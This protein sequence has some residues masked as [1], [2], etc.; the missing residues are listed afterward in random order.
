[1]QAFRQVTVLEPDV[2]NGFENAGSV[3]VQEGKYGEAIPYLQKALQIEADYASYS[4]LGVAYT[5]TKQ[6][7]EAS[8]VLEKAL[9]LNQNDTLTAVNLAD[10]YRGSGQTEKAKAEYQQ[11]ISLGFRELQTNPKDA[12]VMALIA[13]SYAKTG[14]AQQAETFIQRA[15]AEHKDD[16]D[17]LYKEAC[18]NALIGKPSRALELLQNALEKHYSAEYASADLDLESLHNN[19]EFDKL[20][21]EYSKKA[22]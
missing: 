4:N 6:Y 11:A 21:K 7:T 16:V 12:D 9:A 17:I 3:L 15:R 2:N 20:I 14:N 1:M 13:L 19:P 5:F 8:Q 18:V 10:V 22:P